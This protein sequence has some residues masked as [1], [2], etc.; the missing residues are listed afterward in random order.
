MEPEAMAVARETEHRDHAGAKIGMW[1]FLSTEILLFGGLFLLYSAYRYRHAA[2][3]HLAADELDVL[4]GAVNTLILLTSSFT[5][6][7]S[8]SYLGEGRK[9]RSMASLGLTILFGI[10]FLVN[11]YFEWSAKIHHGLYPDSAALAARSPGE[12][13]FYGLYYTMTGMHGLHVLAGVLALSVV[14]ALIIR[15]KVSPTNLIVLDNA[16]LYWH[17]VDI[18]WIYLFPLFYLIT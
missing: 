17:L 3:F 15:G 14:M 13:L 9:G 7:M 11:K 8:I 6:A 2:D 1:L 4:L 16:G 12:K 18:I 10:V 5:M